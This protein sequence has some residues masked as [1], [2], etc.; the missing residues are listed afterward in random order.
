MVLS[1]DEVA[2][3][4]NATTTLRHQAALSVAYGAG[5]RVGE[6][7][8][9]KVRNIDSERMLIRVERGKGGRYRNA[10]LSPDLL[11]LLR[12]WWQDGHRQGVLHRDG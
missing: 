7:A 6:V 3:L 2:R 5:L 8:M 10:M 9:L 4:L 1:R 12:Q 11:T